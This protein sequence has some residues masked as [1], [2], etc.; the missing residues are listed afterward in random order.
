MLLSNG[1]VCLASIH[2]DGDSVTK[3]NCAQFA[4][5][6][7]VMREQRLDLRAELSEI[8]AAIVDRR[9]SGVAL[10]TTVP[11]RHFL[12]EAFGGVADDAAALL[13]HIR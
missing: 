13:Q 9:G 7:S 3:I 6:R 8:P 10:R 2:S 1:G 12:A 11:R 4:R 5:M